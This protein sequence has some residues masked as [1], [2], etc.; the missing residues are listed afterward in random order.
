MLNPLSCADTISLTDVVKVAQCDRLHNWNA[1]HSGYIKWTFVHQSPSMSL[2]R[3]IHRKFKVQNAYHKWKRT[4]IH[5]YK[6]NSTRTVYVLTV[7]DK[8]KLGTNRNNITARDRIER[9]LLNRPKYNLLANVGMGVGAIGLGSLAMTKFVKNRQKNVSNMHGRDT[10]RDTP[11]T[12]GM[13]HNLSDTSKDTSDTNAPEYNSDTSE[14]YTNTPGYNSDTSEVYT[15]APGYNSDT[16]KDTSDTNAP[17][18]TS[19]TSKNNS[20]TNASGY[21]SDTSEVYTNAPGYNSDTSEVYTNAPEYNSDTFRN[22]LDTSNDTGHHGYTPDTPHNISQNMNSKDTSRYADTPDKT[23]DTVGTPPIIG[24][25]GIH[26]IGNTCY[27]VSLLQAYRVVQ[28][29]LPFRVDNK[30]TN[31]ISEM[32]RILADKKV[33]EEH[34]S[35]Q[36]W[37]NLQGNH[38]WVPSPPEIDIQHDVSEFMLEL[39]NSLKVDKNITTYECHYDIMK[40]PLKASKHPYHAITLGFPH[41]TYSSIT[42]KKL[43]QNSFSWETIMDIQPP[44]WRHSV[45]SLKGEILPLV[46]NRFTSSS[47]KIVTP[48]KG[49]DTIRVPSDVTSSGECIVYELVSFVYHEGKTLQGGHYIAFVKDEMDNWHEYDDRN[50]ADVHDVTEYMEQG[51]LYFYK[52]KHIELPQKKVRPSIKVAYNSLDVSHH[53]EGI[54]NENADVIVLI[55]EEDHH[56]GWDGYTRLDFSESHPP[57][58]ISVRI[59]K[60]SGWSIDNSSIE[61]V[62]SSGCTGVVFCAISGDTKVV[63]SG[64]CMRSTNPKKKDEIKDTGETFIRNVI[65]KNVHIIVGDFNADILAWFKPKGAPTPSNDSFRSLIDAKY[66]AMPV[67]F[68]TYLGTTAPDGIWY[69]YTLD[70]TDHG[71]ISETSTAADHVSNENTR[72]GLHATFTT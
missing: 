43:F 32:F 4:D 24:T 44:R 54:F 42:I 5:I 48:V 61:W 51:Y 45:V 34:V 46:L 31:T 36:L 55:N 22:R 37:K 71:I 19:D 40:R 57:K 30:V 47:E 16:S 14:V 12:S 59:K 3:F 10:S 68:A 8:L 13:F 64:V 53:T 58:N 33:V 7:V 63:I 27:I 1:D 72:L 28:P 29:W 65:T 25:H 49:M 18:Y 20:D 11:D 6:D 15:D 17:E 69:H 21:N 62:E 70:L 2:C 9:F 67:Y 56:H 41:G 23:S 26:R 38:V 39:F 52:K 60:E 35:T 66:F 50:R